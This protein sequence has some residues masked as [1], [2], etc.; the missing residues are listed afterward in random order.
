MSPVSKIIIKLVA[1]LMLAILAAPAAAPAAAQFTPAAPTSAQLSPSGARIVVSGEADVRDENGR[2]SVEF[3]LPAGA[4]NFQL[5]VPGQTISR[6]SSLQVPLKMA[7]G[8]DERRERLISERQRLT[9]ELAAVNARIGLWQSPGDRLSNQELEQRSKLMGAEMP[10]LGLARQGLERQLEV[11]QEELASMPPRTALGQRVR[12]ILENPGGNA[13][14]LP[15]R[16]SYTLGSCGWQPVYDFNARPQ[17]GKGDVV[18]VRFLAEVWQFSGMD[19]ENTSLTL[20]TRGTGP[21]EPAPL[22]RWVV[23]SQPK[24]Q[25]REAPVAMN[26]AR[27][28]KTAESAAMLDSAAGHSAVTSD[29]SGVYANWQLKARGLQEGRARLQI[30]SDSWEAPLQWLARPTTGDSRVWLLAKCSLP[31]GQAWP[32]G[33]AQFSVDG[34][35]V[36]E[37][38]FRPRGGEATLYF[39]A[40]P[41]VNVQTIIDGK[42]KAESGFINTSNTWTWAWTY[43]IS[44]EHDR[45][46]AVRVER[47]APMIVDEGVTVS[48]NNNPKAEEDKKKHM[49]YWVVDVP[50]K[51]TASIEHSVTITS[52][53]KLPLLPDVP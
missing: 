2:K 41:R 47:P 15:V 52:P 5:E 28:A 34:Q 24:P 3:V 13:A 22:A 18:D 49:L 1:G 10:G 9:A 26:A 50:A 11:V 29:A 37:G 38:V 44:N 32:E 48:Y 12:A 19:W 46:V 51:G 39:G 40:D 21:R 35:S 17:F 53:T 6:W 27:L 14:R 16:Y 8:L 33:R 31:A 4:E 30:S 20:A 36:G 43:V 7:S 45:P 42:K 23:E 25:P